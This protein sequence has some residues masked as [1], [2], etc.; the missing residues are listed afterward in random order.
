ARR[1]ISLLAF[2]PA[3]VPSRSAMTK[4]GEDKYLLRFMDSSCRKVKYA[5]V[6]LGV[7]IHQANS[8]PPHFFAATR[9]SF[10]PR[11][12]QKLPELEHPQKMRLGQPVSAAARSRK[13]TA[14]VRL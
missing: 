10:E 11:V 12:R 13:S 5:T 3:Q 6:T 1:V 14:T 2:A 7:L 9:N 8:V 4:S